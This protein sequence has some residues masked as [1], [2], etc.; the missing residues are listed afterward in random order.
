MT[1]NIRPII[2]FKVCIHSLLVYFNCI[3]IVIGNFDKAPFTVED[4]LSGGGGPNFASPP[5]RFITNDN[6]NYDKTF[7]QDCTIIILYVLHEFVQYSFSIQPTTTT[8]HGGS[9]GGGWVWTLRRKFKLLTLLN[10]RQYNPRTSWEH[11]YPLDPLEHFSGSVHYH[12]AF[13]F[14]LETKIVMKI[15]HL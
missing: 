8:T 4:F 6:S 10:Y 3:L 2:R 11:G 7:H 14:N 13:F 5:G 9:T 12:A 15:K 1:L